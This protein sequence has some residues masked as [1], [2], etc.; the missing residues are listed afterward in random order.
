VTLTRHGFLATTDD[1]VGPAPA[2]R[3]WRDE[4]TA[5]R[6]QDCELSGKSG[7]M[8]A[9]ARRS[10]EENITLY[11]TAGGGVLQRVIEARAARSTGRCMRAVR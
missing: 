2:A 4:F 10:N 3:T 8:E 5:A 7:A 6:V 1:L 11:R 9:A